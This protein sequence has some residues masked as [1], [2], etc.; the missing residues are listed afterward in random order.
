MVVAEVGEEE[1]VGNKAKKA[2]QEGEFAL[3]A[4]ISISSRPNLMCLL[5]CPI[6]CKV[7]STTICQGVI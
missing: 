2:V 3:K 4:D 5:E 6:L 7:F 1:D